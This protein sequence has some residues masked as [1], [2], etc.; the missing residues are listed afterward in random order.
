M[1]PAPRLDFQALDLASSICGSPLP[2]AKVEFL[3]VADYLT[4]GVAFTPYAQ[5][6]LLFDGTATVTSSKTFTAVFSGGTKGVRAWITRNDDAFNSS[7]LQSDTHLEGCETASPA[8]GTDKY[9]MVED[10]AY[11]STIITTGD[12]PS[13]TAG[14]AD[15]VIAITEDKKPVIKTF[16]AYHVQ[17][18]GLYVP[19]DQQT[20]DLETI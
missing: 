9:Q 14:T 20:V 7:P 1:K 5:P 2:P 12:M 6:A 3:I 8:T 15:K 19:P 11:E 13:A 17:G 10:A 4:T 16:L 18:V